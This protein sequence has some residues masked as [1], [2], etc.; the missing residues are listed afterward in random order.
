MTVLLVYEF[1]RCESN[2]F[3]G[4]TGNTRVKKHE[5]FR[6]YPHQGRTAGA[7]AFMRVSGE[8]SPIVSE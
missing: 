5:Y 1:M 2:F 7:A 4:I 3:N 6:D 8:K